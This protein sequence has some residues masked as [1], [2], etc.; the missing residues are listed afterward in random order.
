LHAELKSRARG[1]APLFHP[2]AIAVIGA[3]GNQSKPGG[4]VLTNL[5]EGG[6]QGKVFPVNPRQQEIHGLPCYP[7]VLAVPEP[8]DLAIVAVAAPHVP[9]I[10][11]DCA[12]KGVKGVIIFT[13]G[14]AE[15]GDKGAKLQ[16]E[17]KNFAV[18]HN[19]RICGPNCMGIVN[20][21]NRM[22]A[23][24]SFIKI[25]P[26]RLP[27]MFSTVGLITQSGGF[28]F[29]IVA[30]GITQGIG[31]SHFISTG[32]EAESDFSDF[33]AFLVDDPQT[34]IIAGYM[35]GIRNGKKLACAADLALQAKKPVVIF[36]TGR[37]QASARAAHSHTG[38]LAGSDLVYSSFFRQKGIIRPESME[39]LIAT[40]TLLET[41]KV[42]SGKKVAIFASSGGHGVVTADKCVEAG[43]E[44]ATLS[45]ETRQKVAALL[46]AYAS[47]ANPIDSTGLDIISPGLLKKCAEI[48]AGDPNVDQ[49]VFSIWAT[50]NPLNYFVEQVI[51]IAASTPK[52]VIV[53]IMGS[54]AGAAEKQVRQ[55]KKHGI[56]ALIGL[57]FAVRAIKKVADYAQKVNSGRQKTAQAAPPQAKERVAKILAGY[58]PGARLSEAQAK[59][60]LA[61]YGI[62]VTKEK[63]AATAEEAAAAAAQI[64]YP[65][66]LK[67]DSPDIPHKTEAG[68]VRLN[69]TSPEQVKEAFREIIVNAR[70][71]KPEANIQ[72]VL[73]QEMLRAGT[74]VIVGTSNDPVFG[75]TVMFGLGGTLVEYLG[76]ISLRVPPFDIEEA[77][78]MVQEIKGRHILEGVRGK[79]PADK[80]AIIETIL[81]VAEL[82]VDFPQIAEL[83]INPL[84]TYEEGRGACAADALIILK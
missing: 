12:A 13:S 71:Y 6:F 52:P 64:G 44:V 57:D 67:I 79:P 8:V 77:R 72:G 83:D 84:V 45:A 19:L 42:S 22:W 28:G 78:E 1:L 81:K 43:L 37:Y 39:E 33:L 41:K 54:D 82:A 76:D 20:F 80:Q 18:R 51:Q 68:G 70:K 10:L 23:V 65:V 5:L 34:S 7:T 15:T 74:E 49:L 47:V 60:I 27:E 24:F 21:S 26:A 53:I 30:M 3:S 32:N 36:K 14:F 17:L 50:E 9:G 75:P 59:E 63:R 61:V 48:V 31:F 66:A 40:L 62:P 69:L 16:E 73:V 56:P 2:S 25:S 29:S 4:I 38:A 11:D 58:A 46:P 35:E 55:L